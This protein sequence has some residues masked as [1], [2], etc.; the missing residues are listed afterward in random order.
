[1]QQVADHWIPACAGMTGARIVILAEAGIQF[2]YDYDPINLWI[3][4]SQG[5]D[6]TPDPRFMK[7]EYLIG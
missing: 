7:F 2:E 3:F 1:M 6:R 5:P 4:I